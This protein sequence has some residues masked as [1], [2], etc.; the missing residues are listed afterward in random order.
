MGWFAAAVII[1]GGIAGAY[2]FA[3]SRGPV[4]DSPEHTEY[5]RN[6][7][8]DTPPPSITCVIPARNEAE[9]IGSLLASLGTQ[10]LAPAEIIV[11][12]DGSTDSTAVVAE[13]YGVRVLSPP[14]PG[15]DWTGK[16]WACF[17]GA[18]AA[19]PDALLVFIDADVTLHANALEHLVGHIKPGRIVSVQ[20]YHDVPTHTEKLS[21]LFN[22]QVASAVGLGDHLRTPSG[23]FG[24]LIAVYS[25]DYFDFGG[26]ESVAASILEDVELGRVARA[27]GM[28]IRNYLGGTAVRYRMY[29]EGFTALVDGWT[30]N[31]IA[32]AGATPLPLLLLESAWIT[33]AVS[34]CVQ[35]AIALVHTGS[36]VAAASS[37]AAYG[38]YVALIAYALPVH[39]SFGVLTAFL[40]PL[41]L[42]GYGYVLVRSLLF[43]FAGKQIY[44]RGRA[45]VSRP[46]ARRAG[47]RSGG[48]E[49][50]SRDNAGR[51][52]GKEGAS[53]GN[54]GRFRGNEGRFRDNAGRFRH[55]GSRHA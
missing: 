6:D 22:L 1:A 19:R 12:D 53:G 14:P 5:A 28:E 27:H 51:F 11:V 48:K 47:R 38:V 23:L 3:T 49:G 42:I 34:V 30:K 18:R 4:L 15:P 9:R 24:P 52:R 54:E 20:P 13:R 41:H 50:A 29:P 43:R 36:T 17:Q 16:S 44:W 7:P 35:A 33:G 25:D 10:S 37:A 40:F 39:G 46:G 45:L 31:F 8:A 55:K 21:A 2:L 26:H 32:G